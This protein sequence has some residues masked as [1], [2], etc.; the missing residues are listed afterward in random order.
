MPVFTTGGMR[1]QHDWKDLPPE[2]VTQA[3]NANVADCVRESL[4]LGINHIETA[5]GYGTSEYQLGLAFRKI[6]REALIVQTK[7]GIG[8]TREDFV[9]SFETSMERLGLSHV[10]LLSIHGINNAAELAR[11]L[12]YGVPQILEWKRQGRVRFLGF[13]T[14]GQADIIMKAAF[15]GCFD[16]MNVHWYFVNH[17]NW[18]AIQAAAHQDMGV[19]IISPNDKGGRL[20]EP[21]LKLRDFC[22]PLTPMQFNALYCL[23]REEVHTLSLG[24]RTP[25]EY[26]EHIEG[27]K[28]YDE[29]A[30][31][32]ETIARRIREEIDRHFCPGWH[33]TYAAGVPVPERCPG[34]VHVREVLRLYTWAKAMDMVEFAKSRYNLFGNGGDW[35]P[36]N[37]PENFDDAEMHAALVHSPHRDQIIGYLH[38]AREML[39]G[40]EV[41][42][43]SVAE[44]GREDEDE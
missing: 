36:G 2:E 22:R 27:L 18:S 23:S 14:H 6:P 42:R 9:R 29:R 30:A 20:W 12:D 8:E 10:D 19:F 28:W 3:S 40:E 5:R 38:A 37:K 21:S 31:I 16:Y 41:K 26:A 1:Y 17:D 32:S 33:R 4:A 7:I 11:A 15:S 25:S 39:K 44:K 24:V 13:S 35:F 34:G 43:Q